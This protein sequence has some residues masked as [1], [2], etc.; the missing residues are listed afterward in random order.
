MVVSLPL[1]FLKVVT[2][3]DMRSVFRRV[4]TNE[5]VSLCEVAGCQMVAGIEAKTQ[6]LWAI[7]IDDTMLTIIDNAS[8]PLFLILIRG[9]SSANI[10]PTF[11]VI[12]GATVDRLKPNY[13]LRWLDLV[14]YHYPTPYFSSAWQ[15]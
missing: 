6:P 5:N 1:V 12:A 11:L 7:N 2:S 9:T 3:P 15:S 13:S 4:G 10:V 8:E 14:I